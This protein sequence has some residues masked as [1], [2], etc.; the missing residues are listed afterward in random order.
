VR[1]S[2]GLSWLLT[3]LSSRKPQRN[4]ERWGIIKGR[5][6]SH[7]VGDCRYLA[8]RE[9]ESHTVVSGRFWVP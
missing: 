2:N 7:R 1:V 3:G 9:L 8:L 4:R 6:C 5:E